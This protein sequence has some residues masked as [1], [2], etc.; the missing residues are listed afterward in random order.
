MEPLIPALA[1]ACG[2]KY[3]RCTER[4]TPVDLVHSKIRASIDAGNPVLVLDG[5]G[6]GEQAIC[7]GY[8]DGAKAFLYQTAGNTS[9]AYRSVPYANWD[10]SWFYVEFL[11]PE[12]RPLSR[13]QAATEAIIDAI[14][15]AN[16][17]P[18]RGG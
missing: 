3:D 4:T 6:D 7:V 10:A 5:T 2:M 1:R 17:V 9:G 8:D 12:S 11:T 16:R 18:V 14:G 13:Q 15:H